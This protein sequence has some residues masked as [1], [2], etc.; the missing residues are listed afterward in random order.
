MQGLTN[1]LSTQGEGSLDIVDNDPRNVGEDTLAMFVASDFAKSA[2]KHLLQKMDD[3]VA[4]QT[5]QPN[6]VKLVVYIDE[7]HTLADNEAPANADNKYLY[8]VLCSA[9]SYFVAF[10]LFVIYLSTNSH[11]RNLSPAQQWAKSSRAREVDSMQA[12]ITETP[13]DCAPN[14]LIKPSTLKLEN[15]NNVEFMA[16]FGRPL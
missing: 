16:Q 3:L 6:D 12:P 7:A 15:M 4:H 5:G 8:D 9:L 10:P 2:L 11:L 14:L 13:F 1:I